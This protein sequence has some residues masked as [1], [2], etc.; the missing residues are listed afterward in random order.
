MAETKSKET[1]VIYF[2]ETVRKEDAVRLTKEMRLDPSKIVYHK[3]G[4]KYIYGV[5][6]E[7]EPGFSEG[8]QKAYVNARANEDKAEIRGQRC[9]VHGERKCVKKCPEANSCEG[10]KYRDYKPTAISIEHSLETRQHDEFGATGEM[11]VQQKIELT[12]TIEEAFK[13]KPEEVKAFVLKHYGYS[14]PEIQE[15]LKISERTVRRY[16]KEATA[17]IRDIWFEQ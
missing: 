2:D 14:N 11:S 12:E 3:I 17:L 1:V 9:D 8:Y 7:C 15:R 13:L 10:C 16:V 5:E 4:G 6:M